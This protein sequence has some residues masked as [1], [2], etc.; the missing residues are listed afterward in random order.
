MRDYDAVY[1]EYGFA[2]HVGYGTRAHLEA[3][4]AHGACLIHRRSFRGV[5]PAGDE[6]QAN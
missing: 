1:P 5:L 6:R 3:L 2:S 4:R